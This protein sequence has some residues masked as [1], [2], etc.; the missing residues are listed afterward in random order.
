MTKTLLKDGL[1]IDP[2]SWKEEISTLVI[3]DG[4][5]S[6]VLSQ[7]PEV[8]AGNGDTIIDAACERMGKER[9]QFARL[10]AS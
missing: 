3:E 5:V 7:S 2:A 1:L 9:A 4:R 6:E 10:L 8:S